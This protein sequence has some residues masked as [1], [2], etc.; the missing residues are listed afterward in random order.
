M[1][2]FQFTDAKGVQYFV[3]YR[4]VPVGGESVLTPEQ[5]G[6]QGAGLS[7]NR[8][9]ARLAKS[10]IAFTWYAQIA[11]APD[12]I[13]DPSVAWPESRKLVELG[14][15]TIDQMT[16]DPVATDKGTL[17]APLNIPT[18]IGPAD[19]MLGIRQDAYPLS[20]QHRSD[21]RHAPAI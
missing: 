6:I 21:R 12:V 7:A 10:P 16:P 20:F 8:V 3:R 1:N 9:A 4:F 2:A 5:T 18:G 15:I 13:G 19:P 11:E 17:F 14:V